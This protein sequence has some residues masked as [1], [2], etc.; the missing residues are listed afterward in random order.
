MHFLVAH[1]RAMHAHRKACARGHVKHVA[2]AQQG[3]RA[4]LVEDGAAV[5]LA[6]HL[7]GNAGGD[8]GLDQARDHIDTGALRGQNQVNTRSARLLRQ[9]SDQFFDLFAHHHHQ[10]G[11]FIDH[12][13]DVRQALQRFGRIGRERK[14]V[15][16]KL[17]T[18]LGVVDFDVVARKIAHAQLAHQLVAPL[19]LHHAPVQAMRGLAHISHHRREQM[20]NAFIDAHLQHL[21]VN[22]QEAHIASFGF[23][24]QGEDGGVDAD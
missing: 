20:R 3:F 14:R 11:Q 7:E 23:V 8:V 22:Q 6:A 15:V 5:N 1:K 16:D 12:D 10:I 4:H 24:E 18:R 21:R 2:H 9:A 13:D 17:F 19:H